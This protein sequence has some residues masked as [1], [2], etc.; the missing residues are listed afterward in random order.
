MLK[1]VLL[2]LVSILLMSGIGFCNSSGVFNLGTLT[3]PNVTSRI[4]VDSF[5]NHTFTYVVTGINTNVV[6]RPEGSVDGTTY[7]TLDDDLLDT[8]LTA[9]GTFM[10][11]KASFY[12]KY[13]RVRFVSESG[14]TNASIKV[15]Y[16][17]GEQ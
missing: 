10:D 8:T 14:G 11:R 2:L 12:A 17:G 4:Q 6:L 5:S 9:N 15:Y 16:M 13:V 3:T 7:F 1:K